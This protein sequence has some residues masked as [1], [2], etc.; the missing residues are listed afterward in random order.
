MIC[1][2]NPL[3]NLYIFPYLTNIDYMTFRLLPVF[4]S[5]QE[6]LLALGQ[7]FYCDEKVDNE[8]LI[9]VVKALVMW[10][11]AKRFTFKDG[12]VERELD[13]NLVFPFRGVLTFC[14]VFQV[15]DGCCC[16]F[17][18]CKTFKC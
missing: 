18:F 6:S 7:Q 8:P 9:H 12:E 14:A 3:K 1:V 2:K 17:N 16:L 10:K 11:A 13:M 5:P 15:F 4:V